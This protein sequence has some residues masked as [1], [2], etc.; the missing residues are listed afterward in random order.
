MRNVADD[1]GKG[2]VR[3]AIHGDNHWRAWGSGL[4]E[5]KKMCEVAGTNILILNALKSDEYI[6]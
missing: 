2:F 3:S 1:G 4:R 5:V 6:L